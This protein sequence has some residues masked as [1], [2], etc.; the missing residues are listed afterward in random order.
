ML[1]AAALFNPIAYAYAYVVGVSF[2]VNKI[3]VVILVE[4]FQTQGIS[5]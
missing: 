4:I 5:N 2:I 3:G 1:T